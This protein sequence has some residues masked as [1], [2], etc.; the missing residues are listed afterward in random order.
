MIE[1]IFRRL[2]NDSSIYEEKVIGKVPTIDG[3]NLNGLKA[4]VSSVVSLYQ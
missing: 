1:W 4:S 2:D 3:I